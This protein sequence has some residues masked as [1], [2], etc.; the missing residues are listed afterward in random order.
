MR[1]THRKQKWFHS[2]RF[3]LRSTILRTFEAPCQSSTLLAGLR[4]GASMGPRLKRMPCD[5]YGSACA[6]LHDNFRTA[7]HGLHCCSNFYD[8][9]PLERKANSRRYS[10]KSIR[11]IGIGRSQCRLGDATSLA[12]IQS[13]HFELSLSH[14]SQLRHRAASHQRFRSSHL[15][16][17]QSSR[18]PIRLFLAE[19][20]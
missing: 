13:S 17:H 19:R 7:W 20:E 18:Q 10:Q 1:Q 8:A 6:F 15:R 14:L 9:R 4:E 12:R 5:A 3:T 16:S 11:R 2:R